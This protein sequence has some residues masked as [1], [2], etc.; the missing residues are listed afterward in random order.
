MDRGKKLFQ[1][2][3]LGILRV[4]I[5]VAVAFFMFPFLVH[6]LGDK[7][8]GLW[9]LVMTLVDYYA[10]IRMGFSTAV[11][12]FLARAIGRKDKKEMSH[13]ASTSFFIYLLISFLMFILTIVLIFS[14][15]IIVKNSE[16][17]RLFQTIILILGINAAIAPPLSIFGAVLYSNMEY[18][19]LITADIITLLLK[20]GLIFLFIS[21]GF[22]L[23]SIALIYLFCN[24]LISLYKFLYVKFK[25]RFIEISIKFFKKEKFKELFLY[26]F[27]SFIS[28]IAEKLKYQVD[29]IVITAFIGFAAVT[30]YNI[31]YQLIIYF[32][33]FLTTATGVFGTYVSQEDGANNYDSIRE[34]FIFFTKISTFLSIFIGFS[35]IFY[36]KPFIQRWMGT[37]YDDSYTVLIILAISAIIFLAQH[38]TKSV[39]FGISKNK[40]WAY[41]NIIEG[42]VNVILSLILVKYLG[43]VGV[44][45]GT[46]IPMLIMKLIFQPMY[47][48]KVLN[49]NLGKYYKDFGLDLLMSSS[50]LILYFVI[51]KRFIIPSYAII[52]IFAFIQS[53]I[54]I[55][56]SFR[57]CFKKNEREQLLMLFKR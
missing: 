18:K 44:A 35:L 45:L 30:H 16:N 10:L 38:P 56:I 32:M 33:Y 9:V 57:F 13:I 42:V 34:K 19:N 8:Y 5:T 20:N 22:G 52:L 54:F 21:N 53:I 40:F 12:R 41:S 14:A 15:D 17:L 11:S 25:Y 31:G 46:T 7:T 55:A 48:T 26:S 1:G 4:F 49:I 2:S 43:L 51:V 28:E 3:I 47:V 29:T 24:I 23:I 39:L 50:I 6:K 37:G 36:G 27:Y